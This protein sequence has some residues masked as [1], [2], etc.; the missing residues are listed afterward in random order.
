MSSTSNIKSAQPFQFK[1]KSV[2]EVEKSSKFKPLLGARK[3]FRIND[4]DTRNCA[5]SAQN[6]SRV[7]YRVST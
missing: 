1:N 5:S 2:E 7:R 3:V 4:E 6:C